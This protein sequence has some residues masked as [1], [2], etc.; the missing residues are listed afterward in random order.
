MHYLDRSGTMKHGT[1]MYRSALFATV[2]FG[3]AAISA[4]AATSGMPANAHDGAVADA[5]ALDHV[6][7]SWVEYRVPSIEL[8]RDDGKI[9]S[10][11]HE[12]DDGRPVV[13]NFIY[14]T[15]ATTCP[16]SSATFTQFQ[17]RLGADRGN[18]HMVSIS[19]DPEQDTPAR[20]R[21]YARKFG[22]GPGWQHYTGT[23]QASTAAQQ[24]FGAYRGDKMSHTPV[25][26]LR[27][28][29]GKPWLRIDGFVTPDQLLGHYRELFAAR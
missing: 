7:V 14:T 11:T 23:L 6:T 25:T 10:L 2:F 19:I 1:G 3:F 22:A 24:A 5:G 20:L 13:L 27:A 18:V 26:F 17:A 9:V 4:T 16:L 21:T 29:P 12:L 15:C 8:T 28:S